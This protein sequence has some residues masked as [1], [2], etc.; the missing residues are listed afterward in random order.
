VKLYAKVQT[1]LIS[2]LRRWEITEGERNVSF[3]SALFF[4]KVF[5]YL[6]MRSFRV[7]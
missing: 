6:N 5:F 2:D 1:F 3:L 7:C 4:F